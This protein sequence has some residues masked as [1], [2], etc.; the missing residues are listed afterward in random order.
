M[1]QTD[2]SISEKIKLFLWSTGNFNL[3]FCPSERDLFV[4]IET[5]KS[6]CLLTVVIN[7]LVLYIN[8]KVLVFARTSW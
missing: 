4:F 2:L 5:D 6:V 8:L 7:V 1:G 3:F